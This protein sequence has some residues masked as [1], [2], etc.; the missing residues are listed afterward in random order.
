MALPGT[1]QFIH[2]WS[3]LTTTL[4][5]KVLHL[6][7]GS[8]CSTNPC[9]ALSN[10]FELGYGPAA[11][12]RPAIK[13]EQDAYWEGGTTGFLAREPSC[14]LMMVIAVVLAVTSS[15]SIC[16][17]LAAAPPMIAPDGGEKP[18]LEAQTCHGVHTR[19]ETYY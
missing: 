1:N 6:L 12:I 9:I 4:A 13:A 15:A 3:L 5:K 19:L 16:P 7:Q 8:F 18:V 2:G 11:S 17:A 10:T 14:E